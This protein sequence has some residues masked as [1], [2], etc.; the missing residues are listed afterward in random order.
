MLDV[1]GTQQGNLHCAPY[2]VV[3]PQGGSACRE[4]FAVDVCLYGIAVEVKFN[5]I[6]LLA[7]HIH[8]ALQDNDGT[9]LHPGCGRFAD[10]DVAYCVG[11]GFET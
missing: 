8:V 10:N 9:V 1:G 3:C 11:N 6:V 5:V 7:H 2:A 4:P